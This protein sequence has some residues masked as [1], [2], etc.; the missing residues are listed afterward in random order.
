MTKGHIMDKPN[1]TSTYIHHADFD[2][3]VPLNYRDPIHYAISVLCLEG[4]APEFRILVG[5]QVVLPR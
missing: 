4:K 3:P 5:P 2:E 1:I